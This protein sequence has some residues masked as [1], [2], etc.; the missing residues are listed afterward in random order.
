M[1]Y[2]KKYDRWVSKDGLVYR[3]SKRQDKLIICKLSNHKDGYLMFGVKKKLILVHRIVWETFNGSI[4]NGMEIDHINC[5]RD[6]NR[7]SNLRCVTHKQ[8]NN[9]PITRITRQK[10]L[11]GVGKS[12]FG[13]KFFEYCKQHNIKLNYSTENSWYH[14]HGYFR[15]EN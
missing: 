3:Y 6:D 13:K 15:W 5:I 7:L 4:S 12:E 8:N 10:S 2:N 14:R 1:V 9:N 11:T